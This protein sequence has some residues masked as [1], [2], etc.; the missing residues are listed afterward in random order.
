MFNVVAK[1]PL[2]K[3]LN[4]SLGL[5]GG[6]V[7]GALWAMLAVTVIQVV[8]AMG[9]AGDTITLQTV[10]ETAVVNWLIGINPLGGTLIDI[11][12]SAINE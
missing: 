10:S 2:L 4:K 8:A 7:S 3:Q 9:L 6:I 5:L 1:L 12:N 11:L